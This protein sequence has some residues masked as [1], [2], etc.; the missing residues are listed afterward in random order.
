M[1]ISTVEGQSPSATLPASVGP[2]FLRSRDQLPRVKHRIQRSR[3]FW[4]ASSPRSSSRSSRS[5]L[6]AG[7]CASLAPLCSSSTATA[8]LRTPSQQRRLY[9]QHT[10]SSSDST[11]KGPRRNEG[12][13]KHERQTL[14]QPL[15]CVMTPCYRPALRARQ[16]IS[17]FE[18]HCFHPHSWYDMSNTPHPP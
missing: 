5:S 12:C 14:L 7:T 11:S 16:Y 8:R 10:I 2:K 4:C 17:L 18:N 1:E 6:C 13:R 3:V 15:L 9:H